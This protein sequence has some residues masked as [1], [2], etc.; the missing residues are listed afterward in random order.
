MVFIKVSLPVDGDV[1]DP[2]KLIMK[3]RLTTDLVLPVYGTYDATSK[4]Y[5][6]DVAAL[7]DGW[8]FGVVV[9]PHQALH[10]DT[11]SVGPAAWQTEYDWKTFSWHILDHAADPA[12]A[13]TDVQVREIQA[14]ARSAAQTLSDAMYR[15]P[16]LWISTHYNPHARIIHNEA[17]K[18]QFHQ[19]GDEEDANF[20]LVS[21]TEEEML[22]LGRMYLD[23]EKIKG[24]A[25]KGIHL[26]PNRR[27]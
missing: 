5:S 26:K 3:T 12:K 25:P 8:V 13:L 16:K 1:T 14:A 2:A 22:A 17:G 9:Q 6:A 18:L 21:K 10:L 7:H 19:P 20:S 27:S 15:S 11:G 4:T 24:Y 23:Y